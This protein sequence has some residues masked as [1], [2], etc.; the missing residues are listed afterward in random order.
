[1][2]AR[3]L[4]PLAALL[5]VPTL[6]ACGDDDPA[7][8]ASGSP[9]TPPASET[10]ATPVESASTPEETE[11]VVVTPEAC[12]LITDGDISKAMGVSFEAGDQE[13]GGA[14][15]GDL[16]WKS[17]NCSFEA[18][19]LVEVTVKVTFPQDF[20]QGAFT[21]PMP[22]DTNGVVEPADDVAGA[23]EAWWKVSSPPNFA[24]TLRACTAEA[25]VEVELDYEDGVDYE[26]DPRQ[27]A[28]QIAQL[29]LS[30]LQG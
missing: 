11:P 15:E 5:L 1:M 29:V 12:N 27:Q 3:H 13:G 20:T 2:R 30:N 4:G 28:G 7:E 21:C 14:A 10:S 25:N 26:G 22:S 24:G 19:D 18:E 9:S 23:D 8:Q 16:A 6:A 17:D